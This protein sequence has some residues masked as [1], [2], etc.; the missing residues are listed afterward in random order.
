MPITLE[1]IRKETNKFADATFG[2]DRPY[3]SP[4]HHLK[5][6]VDEL[7]E[8]GDIMEYADCV[9]LLLDSFNK[10]YPYFHTDYLLENCVK[11][12]EINKTREWGKPDKNGIISH[13]K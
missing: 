6:E 13:I 10:K 3:T 9:L 12:I 5:K 7:I 8:S 2:K 11:K 4:L 1:K